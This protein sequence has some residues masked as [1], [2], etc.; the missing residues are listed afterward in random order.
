MLL[1]CLVRRVDTPKGSRDAQI[2]NVTP[3]SSGF[4]LR[5]N[6]FLICTE[7]LVVVES[8]TNSEVGFHNC[9]YNGVV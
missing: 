9:Y 3:I 7:L 8:I 5:R 1:A 6:Q 2:P 4:V